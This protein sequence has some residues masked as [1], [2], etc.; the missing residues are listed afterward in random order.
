MT[1]PLRLTDEELVLLGGEHPAVELP[2][3]QAL[4]VAERSLAVA[5][6]YRGL[7]AR[8]AVTADGSVEVPQHVLDLLAARSAGGPVLVLTGTD[9]PTDTWAGRY[10]HLLDPAWLVE[11]VTADGVH[12]FG[13]AEPDTVDRV[14][15]E[16]VAPL[17]PVAAQG[18]PVPVS[19][20]AEPWGDLRFR[21]DV[22]LHLRRGGRGRLIGVLGG[23]RGTWLTDVEPG[24]PGELEV[25]PTDLDRI[26]R[27]ILSLL[28]QTAGTRR[29]GT[30]TA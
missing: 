1:T 24:T 4:D 29:G 30:M 16:W 10:L 18:A 15:R 22:T 5:V 25:E 21:I 13:V 9:L 2:F 27:R 19:R 7:Y 11:D 14:V 8:G 6:T 17:E 28:P 20:S 3:L 23:D 12:E 26:V